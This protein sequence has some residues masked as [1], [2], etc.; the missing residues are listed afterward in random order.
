MILIRKTKNTIIEIANSLFQSPQRTVLFGLL[1]LIF[2]F[3]LL[4]ANFF[5]NLYNS[6][7]LLSFMVITLMIILILDFK[8]YRR[9]IRMAYVISINLFTILIVASQGL[10][11]GGYLFLIVLLVALAFLLDNV[12]NYRRQV[13]RY[14]VITIF[15]FLI[16]I[17]FCPYKSN[18]EV[19]TPLLYHRMFIANSVTVIILIALFT[20][21]GVTLERKA[22]HALTLEKDRAKAQA[23]R[24]IEQNN[25]L[26]EIA[27]MSAHTVRAPLT[28]IM[29]IAQMLDPNNFTNSRD[30]HL[31]NYL[32]I[33]AKELD[34]VIHEIVDKTSKVEAEISSLPTSNWVI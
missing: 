30:I 17:V 28:N 4:I 3:S 34:D 18:W 14:F 31:I 11:G 19:I 23:E 33:S 25:H 12:K 26:R 32:K 22:R 9:F 7:I 27:F 16:C 2:C 5:S 20:Y 29:S 1:G 13:F 6:T 8:G 15:S 21:I 24:I 10:A